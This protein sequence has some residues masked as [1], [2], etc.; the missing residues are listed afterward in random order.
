MGLAFGWPRVLDL[1]RTALEKQGVW[2]LG[3]GQVSRAR[4]LQ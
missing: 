4:E 3:H 2:L 1:L